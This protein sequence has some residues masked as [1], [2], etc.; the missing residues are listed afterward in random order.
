MQQATLS[1]I[2]KDTRVLVTGAARGIGLTITE[3]FSQAGAHVHICDVSEEALLE[4]Q[5]AHPGIAVTQADISVYEQVE[6]LFRQ[7]KTEMGGLD[8]LVN[9]AG[10]SGPT[11]PLE[12]IEPEDWRHTVAVDLHGQFYCTKQAIPMLRNNATGSIVYIASN[13][14]VF[15]YPLRT[16][17]TVSKWAL[18]GLTKTLAMELGPDQI[19]VNAI[20]PG[21]VE[22]PRID[23]VIQH[24]AESRGVDAEEV[25]TTYQRQ[26]SMRTFV[27]A[28]DVA[29]M[30]LFICSDLGARISGQ[31]LGVDGN[32]ETLT[33]F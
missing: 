24:E 11:A 26:S 18:I 33:Q 2:S 28:Q 12:E 4:T 14:A 30:V 8:I 3:S 6:E 13:A 17:Y 22:G 1:G 15:G 19:R 20:C 23:G 5:R 9:N 25:R 21:S 31:I 10:I 27:S 16:P 32:T 7:V 29:N